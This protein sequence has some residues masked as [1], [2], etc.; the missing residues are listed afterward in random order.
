MNLKVKENLFILGNKIISYETEVAK[1][2]DGKIIARGKYSRTTGK[3]L[4]YLSRLA[5]MPLQL[6]NEKRVFYKFEY[7][8]KCN[9]ASKI[10]ISLRGAQKILRKLKDS[11]EILIAAAAAYEELSAIDRAFVEI[12]FHK[13]GWTKE[14][15]IVCS[16]VFKALGI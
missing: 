7:G 14:E 11:K 9:A 1:I 16:D 12:E 5:D 10:N 13:Q 2:K 8:V 3:Q 6:S 15:L 4:G